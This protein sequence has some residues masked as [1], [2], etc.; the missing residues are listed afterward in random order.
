MARAQKHID[1]SL[2]MIKYLLT[3]SVWHDLYQQRVGEIMF[4]N[5]KRRLISTACK[6]H[7]CSLF[8]NGAARLFSSTVSDPSRAEDRFSCVYSSNYER[9]PVLQ[10][11]REQVNI[12]VS[13]E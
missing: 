11:N 12:V 3:Y 1:L 2:D 6:D 5:I 7:I 10:Y 4:T 9:S 8:A 13:N